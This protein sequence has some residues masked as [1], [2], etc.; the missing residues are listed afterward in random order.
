MLVLFYFILLSL[1]ITFCV[2]VFNFF[3]APRLK[4]NKRNINGTKLNPLVSVLIPARNEEANILSCLQSVLKQTFKN[5]EII[6]LDDNSDDNTYILTESIAQTDSRIRIISGLPLSPPWLG[7]NW[8][9]HQLSKKAN[10]DIFLF[11][12]ADVILSPDAIEL[13]LNRMYHHRLSMLSVFP[14]QVMKSIGEYIIVPMMN[15]LLLSFLPL[16]LVY[17]STNKSFVAANGQ[18]IMINKEAYSRIGGHEAVC[19]EIVEDMVIAGN[20]KKAG[21][22]IMTLLGAEAV[23]C[24]MYGS[25]MEAYN[26]FSKNFFAGFNVSSKIFKG[27][28]ILMETVFLLPFI[29]LFFYEPFIICVITI[30]LNRILISIMSRQNPVYNAMLHP[31]QMVSLFLTG[32]NSIKVKQSKKV[33][34]KDRVY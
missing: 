9:C 13:A 22:K 21:H 24:R 29:F 30:L 25:Y 27:L 33:L 31:L 19:S 26:G 10:G 34:W 28:L 6:V 17:S 14:T 15:W 18:F 4:Q 16:R 5:I 7:K 11:I 3:T 8:A 23:K 20:I 32:I 2:V 12:D 1:L